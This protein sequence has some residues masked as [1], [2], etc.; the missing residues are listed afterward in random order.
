[1]QVMTRVPIGH[2]KEPGLYSEGNEE[3]LLKNGSDIRFAFLKYHLG[4]RMEDRSREWGAVSLG[5]GRESQRLF[6]VIQRRTD[7]KGKKIESG[8]L[9]VCLG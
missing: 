9:I 5:I 6:S 1:M 8:V 7:T 3:P 2:A 4:H